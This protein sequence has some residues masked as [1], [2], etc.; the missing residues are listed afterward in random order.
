[1]IG[2]GRRTKMYWCRCGFGA[3][4]VFVFK[5]HIKDEASV[6]HYEISEDDLGS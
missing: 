3:R 5:K 2:P 4:L 1:V 6:A